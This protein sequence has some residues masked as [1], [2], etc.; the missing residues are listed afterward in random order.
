MRISTLRTL[1]VNCWIQSSGIH[2]AAVS[3]LRAKESLASLRQLSGQIVE[4]S[5]GSSLF[6][7]DTRTAVVYDVLHALALSQTLTSH[8]AAS[9]HPALANGGRHRHADYLLHTTE[10]DRHLRRAM[11]GPGTPRGT[12]QLFC[13][14]GSRVDCLQEG[15]IEGTM[16]AATVIGRPSQQRHAYAVRMGLRAMHRGETAATL[17]SSALE[18]PCTDSGAWRRREQPVHARREVPMRG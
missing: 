7:V 13:F 2:T 3:L 12:L 1:P 11:S 9:D 16:V 5:Y 15:T 10:T 18:V 8:C 4:S 6:A 17:P 14:G